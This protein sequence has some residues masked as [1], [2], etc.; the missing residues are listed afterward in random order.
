MNT[1]FRKVTNRTLPVLDDRGSRYY[2]VSNLLG[3]GR[4]DKNPITN[5]LV[6]ELPSDAKE[7]KINFEDKI[8]LVGWK[9]N[10]ARPKSGSP[11]ELH[12][13]WRAKKANLGTWKVFVHIDAPGQRIH[14][15]HDPVAGLFPTRD[16][17]VGDLVH[18]VHTINIKRT[19]TAARFTFYAGLYRGKTRM[20]IKSG[21]KD[22]QNRARLGYIQVR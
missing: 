6:D 4:V 13:Y 8:E 22:K 17:K 2:L 1:Q 9:L 21:S 18:D 19:I 10:P 14:G 20:K 12:M 3:E 5:A 7:V 11:A 15:D 16:W